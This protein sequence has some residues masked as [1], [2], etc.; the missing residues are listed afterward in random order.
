[1][2]DGSLVPVMLMVAIAYDWSVP[3][4]GTSNR[5]DHPWARPDVHHSWVLDPRNTDVGAL[6]HNLRQNT[7]EPVK[8]DCPL[9]TIN[10]T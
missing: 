8:H 6:T 2:I 10:C 1:M 5:A 9:S 4:L 7:P 3:T